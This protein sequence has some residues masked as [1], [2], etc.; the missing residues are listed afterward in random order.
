MFDGT[1]DTDFVW[2]HLENGS[3]EPFEHNQYEED[4]ELFAGTRVVAWGENPKPYG[5]SIGEI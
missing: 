5:G 4:G 2:L 3:W 1:S